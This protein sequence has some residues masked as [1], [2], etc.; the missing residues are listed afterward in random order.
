MNTFQIENALR[1]LNAKTVGV[2]AADR[3]PISLSFPSAIIINTQEHWKSGQHWVALYINKFGY[4]FYFDSYGLPPYISYHVDRIKKNCKRYDWNQ[5]QL[6]GYDTKVC[7]QYCVVFL[8]YMQEGK[9]IKNFNKLFSNS[10]KENDKLVIKLYKK[11]IA[12]KLKKRKNNIIRKFPYDDST[13][14]GKAVQC[15]TSKK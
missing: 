9:S 1:G 14:R 2:F 10:Y 15:C 7:G 6:Q 3:I 4:G 5:N 12:L 13:G 11:I 8:Y